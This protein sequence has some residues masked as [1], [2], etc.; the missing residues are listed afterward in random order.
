MLTELLRIRILARIC[1][2]EGWPI[3]QVSTVIYTPGD[4]IAFQMGRTGSVTDA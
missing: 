2:I 3:E 1:Q 4:Y